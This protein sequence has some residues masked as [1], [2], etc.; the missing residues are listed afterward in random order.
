MSI[1]LPM[2]YVRV[3]DPQAPAPPGVGES[4]LL[5]RLLID[6][7]S[8]WQEMHRLQ[9]LRGIEAV[10]RRGPPKAGFHWHRRALRSALILW[11]ACHFPRIP[12][13]KLHYR[14]LRTT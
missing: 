3:A 11:R 9:E 10:A 4:V 8:P 6:P 13:L 12:P 14:L 2:V 5:T 7:R 1:A